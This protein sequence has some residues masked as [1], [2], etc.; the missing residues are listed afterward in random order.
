M[1]DTRIRVTDRNQISYEMEPYIA[2]ELAAILQREATSGK[3]P[4][5]WDQGWLDDASRLIEASNEVTTL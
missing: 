5:K 3:A 2:D 4:A 1:S